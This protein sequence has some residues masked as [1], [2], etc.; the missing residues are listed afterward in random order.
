MNRIK[1]L[2]L[3]R[4]VLLVL[5]AVLAI[6]VF[7]F[8]NQGYETDGLVIGGVEIDSL[9]EGMKLTNAEFTGETTK[10]EPFIVRADWA[11]PDGPRPELVELSS[12][13]GQIHL[14]TGQVVTLSADR[15]VLY[16]K[17]KLISVSGDVRVT[18]SD[19][20]VLLADAADLDIR[21][22]ALVA[23]GGVELE[24]PLG[25]VSAGSMR[26]TQD[27]QATGQGYIWFE[28]RVRLRI[29]QPNAARD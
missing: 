25:P 18:R 13:S 2:R 26:M 3:V 21:R 6:A 10:G 19:G 17:K 20:Y 1:Q 8:A 22:G 16:M 14:S 4:A 24:T 23:S 27:D 12:P 9:D 28:N 29:E 15:G 11:R 7:W 5:A